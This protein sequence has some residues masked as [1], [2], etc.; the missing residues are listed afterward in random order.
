[1]DTEKTDAE[2]RP[3]KKRKK[4]QPEAEA[5]EAAPSVAGRRVLKTITEQLPVALTKREARE[6]GQKLAQQEGELDAHESRATQ[7]KTELK[8]REAE[9]RAQIAAA[10]MS[11]RNGTKIADVPVQ[12]EADFDQGVVRYLRRDTGEEI[13]TRPLGEDERQEPLFEQAASELPRGEKPG[14]DITLP[15]GVTKAEEPTP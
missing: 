7:V 3:P 6:L 1:M 8:A 14:P 5:T 4:K 15:S 9:I 10:A 13:R 12:L 11:L 2:P